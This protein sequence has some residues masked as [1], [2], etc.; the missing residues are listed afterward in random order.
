M[1][2][3]FVFAFKDILAEIVKDIGNVVFG[4]SNVSLNITSKIFDFLRNNLKAEILINIKYK[5][6]DFSIIGYFYNHFRIV[7]M[8][9]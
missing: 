7:N 6:I 9:L 8:S 3:Q 5:W 4:Y 2:V 1:S